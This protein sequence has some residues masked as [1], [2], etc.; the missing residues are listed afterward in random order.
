MAGNWQEISDQI[1]K[2]GMSCRQGHT[3]PTGVRERGARR[4]RISPHTPHHLLNTPSSCFSLLG[5]KPISRTALISQLAALGRISWMRRVRLE[6]PLSHGNFLSGLRLSG[7]RDGGLGLARF[8]AV[9]PLG[10]H[11]HANGL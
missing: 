9:C 5:S 11:M 1:W 3:H 2:C 7:E 4:K 10:C 8:S 6:N